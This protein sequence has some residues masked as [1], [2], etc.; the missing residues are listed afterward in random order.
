LNGHFAAALPRLTLLVHHLPGDVLLRLRLADAL[1]ALG[2]Q[3][4]AARV[5][6]ATAQLG[7]D[8]GSPLLAVVACRALENLGA[9]NGPLLARLCET[10]AVSSA[11][12]GP[13]GARVSPGPLDEP[14]DDRELAKER[15]VSLWVK[16]ALQVSGD[17]PRVAALPDVLPAMP[18]LS[19][20]SVDRLRQVLGK[21]VVQRLPAGHILMNRGERGESCFL[22]ASGQLRVTAPDD[23]D[24]ERELA[25]VGAGAVIGEMALI[26]GS[27]RTATVTVT[28]TADLL[29][30]G[31]EALATIGDQLADLAPALEQVAQHRW[32]RNLL[33]QSAVFRV[34]NE[35][36]RQQL[37]GRCSA[38]EVPE[39]TVLFAQNENPKGIYLLL[40]G[41]VE[42]F[43][44]PSTSTQ[45]VAQRVGSGAAIAVWPVL[46]EVVSPFAART[47]SSSTIL[48]LPRG[49]VHKLVQAI[50]EFARALEDVAM[51]QALT[52]RSSDALRRSD[53][54]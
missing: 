26:T 19:R 44:A 11:R 21:I 53:I 35:K 28:E 46:N 34:F 40:R 15:D 9:A 49:A 50:P 51:H 7:I 24:R 18:I 13:T 23:T 41:E 36:Q 10:Y 32:M 5:Y 47:Q 1:A 17:T 20:L 45:A 16:A 27:P 25:V 33:D 37:L 29:E 30:I 2:E 22:L 38:Y 43:A 6:S 4:A 39:G 42:L 31:P 52:M 12:M 8:G 14:V 54:G 48:F 3:T